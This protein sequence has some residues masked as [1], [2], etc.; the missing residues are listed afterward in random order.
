ALD[1]QLARLETDVPPRTADPA[2]GYGAEPHQA[3]A[4]NDARRTGLDLC[5]VESRTEPGREA[6]GEDARTVERCLGGDLRQRDLRHDGVLR[7]RRRPHEVPDRLAVARQAR[8]PVRQKALVL[9]LPD[10]QAEVRA[11]VEAVRALAALRREER[12]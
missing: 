9:L 1:S 5:G 11:R 12:H 4:E 6:A 7:E 10:R 3:C 8:S 2:T